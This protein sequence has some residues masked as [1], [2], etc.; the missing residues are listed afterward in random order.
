MATFPIIPRPPLEEHI[1]GE[2]FVLSRLDR[3]ILLVFPSLIA[4]YSRA[5][6]VARRCRQYVV[7]GR[8]V[9]EGGSRRIEEGEGAGDAVRLELQRFVAGQGLVGVECRAARHGQWSR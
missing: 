4:I 1:A 8:D 3:A 6:C 5:A 7:L 9:Q 2:L